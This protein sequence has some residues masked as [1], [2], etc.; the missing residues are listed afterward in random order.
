MIST[1]LIIASMRPR[2]MARPKMSTFAR[3]TYVRWQ[4]KASK[5]NAFCLIRGTRQRT[6]SSS[7]IDHI[8]S[9]YTTLKENRMV[10]L[11]KEAGYVH[12]QEL[13]WTVE[14]LH[15]GITVRLK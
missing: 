13:E 9:L 4:T 6:I 14:R 2:W 1:R 15:T 12:L 7:S 5:H 3:C 8:A 11:S 10:S